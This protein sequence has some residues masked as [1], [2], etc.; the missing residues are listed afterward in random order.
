MLTNKYFIVGRRPV[1]H[2][3]IPGGCFV[4]EMNWETGVFED[5]PEYFGRR[6]SAYDD[7]IEQV[8]EDEFILHVES[9]RSQRY[10]IDDSLGE[11]YKQLKAIEDPA[12][13][14]RRAYTEEEM[15]LRKDSSRRTHAIFQ[16]WYPDP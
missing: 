8:T 14:E 11:L 1:K 16:A 2:I 15:K 13:A 10:R 12:R 9:L 7:D 5:G 4:L 3:A 6:G